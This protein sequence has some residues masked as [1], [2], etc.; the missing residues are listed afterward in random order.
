MHLIVHIK[1]T[2]KVIGS[3]LHIFKFQQSQRILRSIGIIS[4]FPLSIEIFR[5]LRMLEIAIKER[6][7]GIICIEIYRLRGI[8][9]KGR[10]YRTSCISIT[11]FLVHILSID[12]QIEVIVE[13]RRRKIPMLARRIHE[14]STIPSE[15]LY[16]KL[17]R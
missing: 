6:S 15:E 4:I 8:H 16:P 3:S 1:V 5:R 14:V 17:K 2:C 9:R 10:S 13:E 11:V 7:T 12:L